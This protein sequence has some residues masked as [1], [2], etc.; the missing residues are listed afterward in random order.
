[1]VWLRDAVEV[2]MIQVQGSAKVRLADGQ[3]L[4]LVYAGRNGQPYTSIGRILVDEGHIHAADMSLA[5]LKGWIRARGQKFGEPG[6]ALMQQNRSY[7]FF[8]AQSCA[9]LE[10]GPIGGAGVSLSPLRSIAVDRTIWSYGL[11]FWIEADIP[12]TRAFSSEVDAGSRKENASKQESRTSFRFHRNEKGSSGGPSP[13][14]RLMIAQDTGSAILGPA[15]ADLYFGSGDEAGRLAAG[16][17]HPARI[18]V[19][20]PNAGGEVA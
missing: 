6:R 5:A 15:R 4:R 16:I 14:R 3:W 2:F 7:V 13:F 20:L 9:D 12:W 1:L 17:R 8:A 18:V 10:E 19:L 11:P